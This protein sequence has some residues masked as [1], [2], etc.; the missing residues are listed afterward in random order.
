MDTSELFQ[1]IARTASEK[2]SK[3]KT[4]L[5][6]HFVE[7]KIVELV[8]EIWQKCCEEKLLEQ[9][10]DLPLLVEKSLEVIIILLCYYHIFYHEV[11]CVLPAP[12]NC[13]DGLC[14]D[15]I[16][17]CPSVCLSVRCNINVRLSYKLN[18]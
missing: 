17:C 4:K 12:Y 13:M 3:R 8:K 15:A 18:C 14:H 11:L 7:C 1:E 2:S 6:S 16:V 9:S 5:I 10:E